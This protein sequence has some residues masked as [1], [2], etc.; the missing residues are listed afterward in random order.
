MKSIPKCRL[1]III[2]IIIIIIKCYTYPLWI[3]KI[4]SG[5]V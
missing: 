3:F 4:A 1:L 2:I 5:F